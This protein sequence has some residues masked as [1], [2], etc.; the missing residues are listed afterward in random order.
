AARAQRRSNPARADHH[1]FRG[2]GSGISRGGAE[3]GRE[4]LP[5]QGLDRDRGTSPTRRRRGEAGKW[6]SPGCGS[7]LLVNKLL[8]AGLSLSMKLASAVV[9]LLAQI[10]FAQLPAS[11]IPDCLGVNIHFTDPRP[12]EMKMLADAGF[13]WVRMDFH[14]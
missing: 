8:A 11:T 7:G 1:V 14:W 13:R 4:R 12:G 9:L 10:A 5:D 6:R 3:Q 2:L